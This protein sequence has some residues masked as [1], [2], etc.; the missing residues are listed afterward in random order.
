MESYVND[1]NGSMYEKLQ[2]ELWDAK[3]KMHKFNVVCM[4]LRVRGTKLLAVE[5]GSWKW[6][7]RCMGSSY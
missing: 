6:M 7:A 4:S 3:F 5:Y 1:H 2:E